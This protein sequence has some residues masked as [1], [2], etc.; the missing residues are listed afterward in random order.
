[1]HQQDTI[2]GERKYQ[3]KKKIGTGSVSE[4]FLCEND[5]TSV[6]FDSDDESRQLE[7]RKHFRGRVGVFNL[8]G[9]NFV[10][11]ISKKKRISKRLSATS[12]TYAMKKIKLDLIDEDTLYEIRNEASILKDLDHP[13]SY[14][15]MY[16]FV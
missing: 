4:I 14:D 9:N 2:M 5:D 12:S 11:H 13:V 10:F 1:M 3:I 6:I 15:S 8:L 7:G 16:F